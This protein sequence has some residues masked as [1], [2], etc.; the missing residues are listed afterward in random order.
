VSA[1]GEF[2]RSAG[3]GGFAA[4]VAAS[5]AYVSSRRGDAQQQRTAQRDRWWDQAKW[6]LDRLDNPATQDGALAA[7]SA[8]LERAIDDTEK[9]FVSAA[10]F[11][12]L[13]HEPSMPVEPAPGVDREQS[14]EAHL[15]QEER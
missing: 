2:L 11:P 6:A 12:G 3:F 13:E 1:I 8:L 4:V 7:L 14:G 10:V 9:A 15:K 5:I